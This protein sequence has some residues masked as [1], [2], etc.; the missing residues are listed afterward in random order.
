MAA[1][2]AQIGVAESAFSPTITLSADY[3]VTAAALSTLFNSASRM[4][5]VGATLAQT[6][7]DAG[8]RH[9]LVEAD[10]AL[11]DAAVADY[12]QVVLSGFQQVEDGLAALRIL[13]PQ[14][15][16][17]GVAGTDMRQAE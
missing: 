6:V 2:N 4:W 7:F 14:A 12:R 5:S 16:A 17:W 15:A 1:A 9:A 8:G 10:R 13:A 3:G 11:L